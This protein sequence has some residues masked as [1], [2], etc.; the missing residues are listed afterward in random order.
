M[1]SLA[2]PKFRMNIRQLF[3]S[4]VVNLFLG[5]PKTK[6]F[7][8]P[9]KYICIFGFFVKLIQGILLS[10]YP[11]C[12]HGVYWSSF[13]VV[14]YN[15]IH[16][17]YCAPLSTQNFRFM[18]YLIQIRIKNGLLR[19]VFKFFNNSFSSI[20]LMSPVN[21]RCWT[22]FQADLCPRIISLRRNIGPKRLLSKVQVW[23][24][25]SCWYHFLPSSGQALA[26]LSWLGLYLD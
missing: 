21:W 22:D 9:L 13:L 11:M 1:D 3:Q 20:P 17:R 25:N 14:D 10:L 5:F 6:P 12:L 18:F 15:H 16:H 26:Q 24:I 19:G 8:Y 23:I 2:I 7:R 4:P